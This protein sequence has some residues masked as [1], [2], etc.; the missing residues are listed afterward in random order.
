[1]VASAR[2]AP[3]P[4]TVAEVVREDLRPRLAAID[5]GAY[6]DAVL[7][8]LGAAGAYAQH[9][10]GTAA[11]LLAAIDAMAQA[12][13][14]CLSTAFCVWC[15]DAL[16]WY[17]ARSEEPGSRRHLVTFA[18]GAALGGTGLSNPMK[19]FS[20]IEPLAL[21]GRREGAGYRVRG[22]LPWV[23]NLA[24]GHRFAGILSLPDGRRVMGLFEAG[25]AAVSIAA[26]A[27]F[28]ALEGTGTVT[29]MVRDAYIRDE[30][31]IAHDAAA[32]VP[33][34][35]N[36][37]VLLQTGMGL[38]LARGVARLMREDARGRHDGRFLPLGPDAIEDR[39]E[40]L[41]ERVA[42]AAERHAETDR[43]TFLDTL[44]LRLDVSFLA[45][46][47]AQ[48]A[49][50]QFGARGY[51]EGSEPFRRLREAQF[52]AIVTP[53]VKHITMELARGA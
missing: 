22:R 21:Q 8:A 2:I 30:D 27:R 26:N 11:G 31:V 43:A 40:V 13:E 12:G 23:S 39:V 6:P 17:L 14:A 4:R 50:L 5:A 45:L 9:G 47:A 10:E 24:P 3:S 15:Q 34:I 25:S 33:R 38:G 51:L 18:S 37:F 19:A 44:R 32:F 28:V 20:G 36:G 7:R 49:M 42:A 41:R 29:V 35:R 1:M 53:S 16:V 48:S 52:V 46:E